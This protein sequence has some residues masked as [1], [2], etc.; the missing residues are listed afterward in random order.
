MNIFFRVILAIYAFFLTILSFVAM[1]AT[2]VD[3][4]FKFFSD[5]INNNVLESTSARVFMFAIAFVF[6]GLSITFLMSGFKSDKDK[7]AVSKLTNIGEIKIS[8]DTLESIVLAA[9]R[10]LTGVRESKASVQNTVDGITVTVKAVVMP[11]INIP[12][13]SE[14]IQNRV[15]KSIEESAGINV[16]DVRVLVENIYSGYRSRVE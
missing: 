3:G 1:L 12:L 9:S 2:V 8:I 5:Y 13:L 14:D 4:A 15:K 6:F 10:K 7:K 16:R 11:D